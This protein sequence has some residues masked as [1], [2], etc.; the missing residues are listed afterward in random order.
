MQ[1]SWVYLKPQT[2]PRGCVGPALLLCSHASQICYEININPSDHRRGTEDALSMLI[3]CASKLSTSKHH[4]KQTLQ[5]QKRL[6]VCVGHYLVTHPGSVCA[7]DSTAILK[8]QTRLT[9][10]CQNLEESCLDDQSDTNKWP[11]VPADFSTPICLMI[12]AGTPAITPLIL[13]HVI[14]HSF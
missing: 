5:P 8:P 11:C 12:S 6:R 2:M 4:Q 9:M 1:A 7:Q 13:A 10:S 14:S 3:H